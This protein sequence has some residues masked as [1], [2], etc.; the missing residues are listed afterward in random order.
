VSA[1]LDNCSDRPIERLGKPIAPAWEG[2]AG[3]GM[4]ANPPVEN[5]CVQLINLSYTIAFLSFDK[6]RKTIEKNGKKSR[7][8]NFCRIALLLNFAISGKL[9]W[10]R[11]SR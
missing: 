6:R 7:L 10:S 3:K 8:F 11:T 2:L 5:N 9:A 4:Q 1:W